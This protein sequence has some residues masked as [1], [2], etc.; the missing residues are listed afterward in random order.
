MTNL[1]TFQSIQA[2]LKVN[3]QG[4]CFCSVTGAAQLANVD[5]SVLIR[6]L[7]TSGDIIP[8]KLATMLINKG[9]KPSEI[10]ETEIPDIALAVILVY[11]ALHSACWTKQA[12]NALIEFSFLGIRTTIQQTLGWKENG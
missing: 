8:S 5:D 12:R 3:N 10:V 9:F 7:K 6:S 2:E 4:E 11:Y 1:T